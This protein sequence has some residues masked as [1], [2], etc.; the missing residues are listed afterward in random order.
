M[1]NKLKAFFKSKI[2]LFLIQFAILSLFVF[3]FNYSYEIDFDPVISVER[4]AI[5]Q[6]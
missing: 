2:V 1:R 5:I 4:K 6:F 3:F